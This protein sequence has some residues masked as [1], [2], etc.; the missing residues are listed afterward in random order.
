MLKEVGIIKGMLTDNLGDWSGI[1]GITW[2]S[3]IAAIG[4]VAT[5]LV[6]G[7]T[8]EL[9]VLVS[10]LGLTGTSVLGK[11]YQKKYEGVK[12]QVPEKVI[13]PEAPTKQ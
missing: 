7:V 10:F 6:Q 5:C 11:A 2:A 3:F 1:R 9:E 8:I 4:Y 13:K 12:K